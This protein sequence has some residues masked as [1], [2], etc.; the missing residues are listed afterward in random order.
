M[1]VLVGGRR[2][3]EHPFR[4]GWSPSARALMATG[5]C[6]LV[7]YGLTRETP[8]ACLFGGVGL[9]LLAEGAFNFGFD[10]FAKVPEKVSEFASSAAEQLGRASTSSMEGMRR[11]LQPTG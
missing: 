3:L 9:L 5:G 4:G 8:A 1:S 2:A 10:D 11:M 7:A 6:G